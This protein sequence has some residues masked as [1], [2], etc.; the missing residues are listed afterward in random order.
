[1]VY[2]ACQ[3]VDGNISTWGQCFQETLFFGD[4]LIFG[5]FILLILAL[6]IWR[7]RLP[8]AVALPVGM[9]A[10]MGLYAG[11]NQAEYLFLVLLGAFAS[12]GWM[13]YALYN[14]LKRD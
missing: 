12:F 10:A 11:T 4:S 3:F 6:V 5:I 7:T 9:L 1:M 8:G 13:G 14:R 2:I